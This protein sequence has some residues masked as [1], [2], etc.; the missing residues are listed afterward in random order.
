MCS[1]TALGKPMNDTAR[2]CLSRW[3]FRHAVTK[4][5]MCDSLARLSS[6]ALLART[7]LVSLSSIVW[8]AL[9]V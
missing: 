8:I 6:L 9:V 3:C 4:S 1:G 7:A 5:L 2:R